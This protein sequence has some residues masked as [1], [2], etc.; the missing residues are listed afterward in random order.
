MPKNLSL[1]LAVVGVLLL[2]ATTVLFL[3]LRDSNANL[4]AMQTEEQETRVR[5]GE[6]INSIATIQDSLNAI[7]LG[8]SAN[9]MLSQNLASELAI[10]PNKGDQVL[11]NIALLK[12]GIER[13]KT[14]ITE[15]DQRLKKNGVQISGLNKMVANL[16]RNVA[17][18]EA[19][20]AELTSRV[21]SLQTQVVGLTADVEQKSATIVTQTA[22]IEEK[23]RELGTVFVAIGTRKNLT[24]A[25]V[26]AAAGGVLGLGKTLKPTGNTNPAVFSPVDTDAQ[27][28]IPIPAAKA[29]VISAQP[30]GSYALE[31][32]GGQL[33]LRIKDP[34]EFRKIKHVVILTT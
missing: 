20:V 18:K 8:D 13:T 34:A 6:A 31:L 15:L 33:E 32:V 17:E 29:Q 21:E 27:T 3:K 10:S 19:V 25:G 23:R 26:V 24:D 7:A 22:T 12:A 9:A 30:A 16:K 28:V 5:Y 11:Q 1:V 4:L 2:G 14:R